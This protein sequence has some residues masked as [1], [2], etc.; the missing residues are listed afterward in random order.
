MRSRGAMAQSEPRTLS[1]LLQSAH[2]CVIIKLNLPSPE[3][4]H[5]APAVT[6]CE[7]SN[8]RIGH[9]AEDSQLC[10]LSDEVLPLIRKN[11][12]NLC[13]QRWQMIVHNACRFYPPIV[14]RATERF[15]L[16][17]AGI[18][19]GGFSLRFNFCLKARCALRLGEGPRAFGFS[20]VTF[21]R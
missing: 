14:R 21:S 13:C 16:A 1:G 18:C 2:T 8:V 11:R 12:R 6:C 20:M 4:F 5:H 3:A 9:F 7:I 10:R 17:G 15:F 19:G